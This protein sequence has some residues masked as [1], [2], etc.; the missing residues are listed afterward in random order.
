MDAEGQQVYENVLSV[1]IIRKK[2]I[3]PQRDSTLPL[4]WLLIK[5]Q[6]ISLSKET[7]DREPLNTVNGNENRDGHYGQRVCM[8]VC[9]CTHTF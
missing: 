1:T 6:E 2:Q 4:G 5:R 7:E 3:K 8:C 9:V